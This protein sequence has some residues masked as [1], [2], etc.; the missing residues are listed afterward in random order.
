MKISIAMP[1]VTLHAALSDTPAA[2]DFYQQLPLS[3]TLTDYAK[4]EKIAD[5]S[6]PLVLDGEPAGYQPQKGDITYYAPWG[7][8]AI[9]YR[10]FG[11][12]SGLIYLGKFLQDIS[13]L[14]SDEKV[15]VTISATA[16]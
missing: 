10:D 13:P 8:L 7:N 6:K 3:L 15:E 1:T 16:S 14:L 5:L 12:A 4:T 9:F 2:R 11:Y